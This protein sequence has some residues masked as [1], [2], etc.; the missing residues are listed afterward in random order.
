LHVERNFV[1]FS[2]MAPGG[3]LESNFAIC[4]SIY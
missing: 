4:N 1:H 2:A 3:I